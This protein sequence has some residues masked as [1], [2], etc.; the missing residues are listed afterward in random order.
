MTVPAPSTREQARAAKAR[1]LAVFE[2]LVPVVGVGV[3]R[4]QAG[5]GVKGNLQT[6]PARGSRCRTRWTACRSALRLTLPRD[7]V[8][9]LSVLDAHDQGSPAHVYRLSVHLK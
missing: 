6:P 8:Y 9:F 3:T 7:G 1:A 2:Q 5:Y 4:V